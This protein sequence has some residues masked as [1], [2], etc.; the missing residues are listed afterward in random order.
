MGKPNEHL[1][2]TLEYMGLTNLAMAKALDFD[3]SLISRYLSGQRR[4]PAASPQMDAIADFLLEH[5]KRLRDV[6]WLKEQFASAGLPTDIS[7][8]YRLKQNLIM[9]LATDGETLRKNLGRTLPGDVAGSAPRAISSQPKVQ[10]AQIESDV[11]IGNLQIVLALHGM[12]ETLPE[13]AHAR[14]FLSSDRIATATDQDFAET[15]ME[16]ATRKKL[17]ISML[18]CVSGDTRSTHKL[19]DSYMVGLIAGYISLSVVHGITQAITGTMHILTDDTCLLVNETLGQAA[20]PIGA[21][22][23]DGRFIR[24]AEDNFDSAARYAQPVLRV[25]SDKCTREVI[26]LLAME[27]CESG[28]LDV[29]KDSVNPMFLSRS[30]YDRFLRTRGHDD[31]GFAWRSAEFARFKT[32]MDESIRS[33]SAFREIISLARLNDIVLRGTCPMAG[34]YFAEQGYL[35]LDRQGCID[36]L[37]GYIEYL[38]KDT[39]F[40]LLILDSLP[41]LH[42]NNCWHIKRGSHVSVN[43]W[44]GGEPVMICSDQLMLLREFQTRYDELWAR[45]AGA[46]GSRAN[47]ISILK[48][49]VE[50]MS[51]T[52]Q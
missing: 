5:G 14:V 20:P 2:M 22:I 16:T 32:G 29:I 47:V 15:L 48:D 4:L 25:Y 44:Q 41:E 21:L 23:R 19:L 8:V 12:L 3:P 13:G 27:Y 36:V 33:G 39:A 26:E 6:E 45:G 42:G 18:I 43:N 28:A 50:R 9:W 49:V 34:L 52:N 38:T 37:N 40:N 24:E 7:T 35:D 30:A 1:R 46:I 11:K 51:K 10:T 17:S 31:A